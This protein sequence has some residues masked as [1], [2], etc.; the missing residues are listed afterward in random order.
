MA[1]KV[2]DLADAIADA[3]AEYSDELAEDLKEAVTET[4]KE[5]VSEI[6]S[7]AP[8]ESGEYKK[9]WKAKTVFED[10]GNIRVMVYNAKKPQI[11]HLLEHGHAKVGGGRVSGHPHIKPAELNAEKNLTKR[12][13]EALQ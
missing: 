7:K 2:D 13:E 9:G 4:A 8:V 1:V 12:V 10:K 11:T 5:C 3:L 6:K